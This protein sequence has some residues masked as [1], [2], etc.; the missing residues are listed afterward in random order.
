[1]SKKKIPQEKKKAAYE[2]D[3]YTFAWNSPHGF[4]KTWK[5][6]KSH[7][8]RVIRR[9][10]R[11]LLHEVEKLAHKELGPDQESL[12]AELF[13]K[14]LS[15]KRLRKVGVVSLR[16]KIERKKEYRASS[17]NLKARSAAGRTAGFRRFVNALLND[18]EYREENV[19]RLSR[20][21]TLAHFQSFLEQEPSWVRKLEQWL[22]SAQRRIEWRRSKR[23]QKPD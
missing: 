11:N 13:R 6:K 17:F 15:R 4:R 12:T 23:A 5:K 10:S 3:H 22:L 2:K 18:K 19:L 20:L 9:K 21:T 8:N 14:G 1:M 7:V 16:E